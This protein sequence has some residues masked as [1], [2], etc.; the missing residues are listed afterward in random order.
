VDMS[1][2]SGA[3]LTG[4]GRFWTSA[5]T[6][7]KFPSDMTLADC[8]AKIANPTDGEQIVVQ[9]VTYVYDG[10]WSSQGDSYPEW[11][12]PMSS[13]GPQKYDAWATKYTVS[14]S[15]AALKDAYLLN[16]ANTA[17]AVATATAAFT[18]T[19]ITVNSDGTVDVGLPTAPEGGFNGSVTVLGCETIDGEYHVL[20]NGT[21]IDDVYR[22][23][24][25]SADRFFK[26]ALDM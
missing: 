23:P 1:S 26:V 14:D 7:V 8:T 13:N 20:T 16:C 9:G 12:G 3:Q 15:T 19:S 5:A 11:I 6:V 10:S 2:L 24:A 22:L 18:A 21:V 25:K 17:E 4:Q